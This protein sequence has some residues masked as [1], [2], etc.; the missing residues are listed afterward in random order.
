MPP[1]FLNAGG[2]N[3]TLPFHLPQ[4]LNTTARHVV[5]SS[6]LAKT[7]PAAMTVQLP[8]PRPPYLP[9][10]PQPAYITNPPCSVMNWETTHACFLSRSWQIR[11]DAMFAATCLGT[12]L[13]C[14]AL[15]FARRLGRTYDRA[16]Y[17]R[18]RRRGDEREEDFNLTLWEQSVR[19]GIKMLE[20]AIGVVLGLLVASFNGF[21]I[22]SLLLGWGVAFWAF[23]WDM[24]RGLGGRRRGSRVRGTGESTILGF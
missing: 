16:V 14:F 10:P 15:E 24:G 12:V 5:N 17:A 19:A 1:S 2:P 22:L 13:L 8:Q 11:S 18:R 4:L 9:I 23:R 21:L 6:A 20:L 7:S 3:V